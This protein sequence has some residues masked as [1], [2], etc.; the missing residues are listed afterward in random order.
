MN[1]GQREIGILGL[2]R[3]IISNAKTINGWRL[4]RDGCPVAT[5]ANMVGGKLTE[6]TWLTASRKQHEDQF[7][8][9]LQHGVVPKMSM[10]WKPVCVRSALS[11]L[12]LCLVRA[13]HRPGECAWSKRFIKSVYHDE[14]G[15][16]LLPTEPWHFSGTEALTL[17][18][19]PRVGEHSREVLVEELGLSEDEYNALVEAQITGTLGYY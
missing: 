18:P 9:L 10:T 14:A 4:R 16:S 15:A 13:L 2:R 6:P 19:S 17:K 8:A 7:E 5:L 11:P 1:P 3:T 12:E